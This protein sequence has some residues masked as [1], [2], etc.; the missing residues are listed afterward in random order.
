M[1]KFVV[2]AAVASALFG[3][4]ALSAAPASAIT[5]GKVAYTLDTST[6]EVCGSGVNPDYSVGPDGFAT[7]TITF[8]G[9]DPM[10]Y[11]LAFKVNQNGAS[12]GEGTGL[13]T[14]TD[15]PSSGESSPGSWAISDP[16]GIASQVVI[17]LKQANSW[18]AFLIS[19][20]SGDWTTS[21]PG[22]SSM[23]LSHADIWYKPGETQPVPLPA[24]LPLLLGGLAG[25][26]F[27]SRRR[28]AA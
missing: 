26:G 25:L 7:E 9:M 15:A 24:A 12:T 10:E 6:A 17:V 19:G 5:C 2:V 13:I 3:F 27:I 22:R 16:T 18:A 21:G 14:F 8:P 1:R 11:I 28:K 20:T 4:V 23:G